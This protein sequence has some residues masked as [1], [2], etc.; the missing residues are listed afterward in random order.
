MSVEALQPSEILELVVPLTARFPG[1]LGDSESPPDASRPKA[2][3]SAKPT[4]LVLPL[5]PVTRR[6][7]L[8]TVRGAKADFGSGARVV[9]ESTHAHCRPVA[10]IQGSCS[11]PVGQVWSI[12]ES[13]PID[14]DRLGPGQPHPGADALTVERHSGW[15][16]PGNRR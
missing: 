6:V 10:E 14:H 5:T 4:A 7:T 8:V 11:N 9:V 12:V 3:N 13:D 1:T 15:S 2:W 16:F